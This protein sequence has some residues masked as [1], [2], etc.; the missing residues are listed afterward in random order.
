MSIGGKSQIAENKTSS[1]SINKVNYSNTT[2][3]NPYIT[4]K[5]TNEGTTTE[6]SQGSGADTFNKF[7][8][9]YIGNVLNDLMNPNVDS[10]RNQALVNSYA[11]N[12]NKLSNI[13][14]ENT[15]NN[16]ANR[17]LIRSSVANDM[18]KKQAETNADNI[19]D[20]QASLM[21][22]NQ[23]NATNLFNTLMNA[24]LQGWNIV[25]GNQALSLDTSRG[26]ATT[27]Q[28]SSGK[29]TEQK[30]QTGAYWGQAQNGW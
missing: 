7:Y 25:S 29:S 3:T 23:N 14:T 15:I 10:A 8:N 30:H 16:L 11:N 20:Y 12:L 13:N 9:Q 28:Q 2:T 24:Y 17:G 19:A 18:Y 6:F 27:T 22:D 21:A 26:N 1:N 4:S 5:T